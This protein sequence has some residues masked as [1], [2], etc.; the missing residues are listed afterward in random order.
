MAIN[1]ARVIKDLEDA[2]LSQ[3]EIC[4]EVGLKPSSLSDIKNGR[5]AE[6]RGNAAVKLND[7]HKRRCVGAARKQRAA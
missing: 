7:L 6:P 4:D 2:G 1:W 3:G 5:S